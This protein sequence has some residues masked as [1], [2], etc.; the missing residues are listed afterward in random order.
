M[1]KTTSFGPNGSPVGDPVITAITFPVAPINFLSDFREVE[2]GPGKVV[3]TDV[4]APQ[5]QPSTVRI[6]QTVRPNV[7]AGSSID[8]SVYLPNKK[9]TDTI[10]ELREIWS[11]VDSTDA[12]FLLQF[13]IRMA[14]TMSLPDSAYVTAD[15]VERLVARLV[16]CLAA[17]G[18]DTP[19]SGIQALLHG[20]V[21]K[22]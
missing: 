20:V 12:S 3:Y 4:T 5:D 1:A 2:D 9:G 22:D 18:M 11:V 6:A 10:I 16:A 7:Y 19:D 14:L 21:K 15:S 8:S 13:P 17:Q